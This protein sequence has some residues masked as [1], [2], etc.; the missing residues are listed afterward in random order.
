MTDQ[1][2]TTLAYYQR[3]AQAFVEETQHLD[4]QALYQQF[5]PLLPPAGHILDLGCGSGRDARAFLDRGYRVTALD[6]S[7]AIAALAERHLGAPVRVQTMESLT[8]QAC[9]DGIWAC[10]S[11]LHLPL[12]RLNELLPRLGQALRGN[13]ILYASFKY[14]ESEREV[15][16]RHFTDMNEERLNTLLSRDPLWQPLNVWIS[17]D[18]RPSRQHESWLNLLLRRGASAGA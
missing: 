8:D 11:L 4:M 14:G 17:H 18:R 10:A 7:P 12:A 5:L 1:T 15:A 9:F 6:A 3:C 13:G 2:A 16:G